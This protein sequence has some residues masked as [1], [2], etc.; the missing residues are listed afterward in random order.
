VDDSAAAAA[1]G[2]GD[3][4]DDD[5]NGREQCWFLGWPFPMLKY[6]SIFPI[7]YTEA[8]LSKSTRKL[9]CFE[10]TKMLVV[11]LKNNFIVLF[12]IISGTLSLFPLL[13]STLPGPSASEVTTLWR[14]NIQML[15][16]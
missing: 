10:I 16:R 3:D 4:D 13:S 9:L 12:I 14:Y 1:G 6:T 2:G 5:D 15:R 7:K 8:I 11:V